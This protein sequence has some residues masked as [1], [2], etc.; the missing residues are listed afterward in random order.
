MVVTAS[1]LW[2]IDTS[3]LRPHVM[4]FAEVLIPRIAAGRVSIC[5][6]TELEVGYSTRSLSDFERISRDVLAPLNRL[7]TPVATE[8]RAREV[9]RA[10]IACGQ[11]RAIAIP[12]LIVAAVAEIEGLTV[13][14]YD[15]DFD[16]I[17][18]ITGQPTEWIV[19]PGSA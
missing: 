3:A 7:I 9:Q 19:P 1:T 4:K 16:L 6:L 11:H 5:L 15:G 12:D 18:D 17:A 14:H 10:L 2:L 13:L 8:A